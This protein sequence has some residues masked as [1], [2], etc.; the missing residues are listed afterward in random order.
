LIFP[1]EKFQWRAFSTGMAPPLIGQKDVSQKAQEKRIGFWWPTVIEKDISG[2]C[3]LWGEKETV[4]RSMAPDF[5]IYPFVT[6]RWKEW[7]T[8][9]KLRSGNLRSVD[10]FIGCWIFFPVNDIISR[11][12]YVIPHSANHCHRK[13]YIFMFRIE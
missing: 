12:V 9:W 10:G 7:I 8:V 3:K 11:S 1:P 13:T 2:E 5:N 4:Y 6:G